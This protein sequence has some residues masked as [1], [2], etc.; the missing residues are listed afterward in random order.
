MLTRP[1]RRALGRRFIQ[2]IPRTLDISQSNHSRIHENMIQEYLK[3]HRTTDDYD[4]VATLTELVTKL[5]D[6]RRNA[7][8]QN[9][10]GSIL[11]SNIHLQLLLN[12]LTASDSFQETYSYIVKTPV[13]F[14]TE[15]VEVFVYNLLQTN[16]IPAVTSLLHVLFDRDSQFTL[17]NEI[18]SL[19]TSKVVENADY[20]GAISIYHHLIDNIDLYLESESGHVSENDNVQFLITPHLLEQMATLFVHSGDASRV[21][22]LL[23]YFKRFYSY[24][25]HRNT[26]RNLKVAVVEAFSEAENLSC[27]LLAFRE[28]ALLFRGHY[29]PRDWEQA[30][31]V[32]KLAAYTNYVW[33][34]NNIM[35]NTNQAPKP[36]VDQEQ[37]WNPDQILPET[38]EN[39]QIY[40]PSYERNVYSGPNIPHLPLLNGSLSISDLPQFY[41]LVKSSVVD[42]MQSENKNFA[43]LMH[44]MTSGHF[45][46]HSFVVQ[47]LC[48]LGYPKEAHSIL[49]K[50]PSSFRHIHPDVLLK[51]ED[52]ILIFNA[53]ETSIAQ[54][55]SKSSSNQL[56]TLEDLTAFLNQVINQY[57]RTHDTHFGSISSAVYSHFLSALLVSPLTTTDDLRLHLEKLMSKQTPHI[58]L[59]GDSGGSFTKLCK[60]SPDFSSKYSSFVHIL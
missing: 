10:E 39:E 58:I 52:F 34:R 55:V 51:D 59:K 12:D 5:P 11:A 8:L 1:I 14:A 15:L 4:V 21:K 22:G 54:V 3:K 30:H 7:V 44:L 20:L 50:L 48:E 41:Q 47:A 35:N 19:Y 32:S 16:N 9:Y 26:Y 23:Q 31:G 46:V 24:S 33:R 17:S 27:A 28:L 25:S 53:V 60:E 29:N 40:N 2:S 36:D 49:V 38:H 13:R 45:M 57:N 43:S 37:S 6:A 42:A 18:W 56:I